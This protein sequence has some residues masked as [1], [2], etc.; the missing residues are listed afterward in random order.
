MCK[1]EVKE[2]NLDERPVLFFIEVMNEE[3]FKFL[4]LV[5]A[6]R[7]FDN[8]EKPKVFSHLDFGE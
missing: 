6:L 4:Y 3:Y 8:N 5:Q 1:R 2:E 7:K